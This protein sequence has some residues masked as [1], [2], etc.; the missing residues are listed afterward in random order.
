[1]KKMKF[2]QEGPMY[3]QNHFQTFA[4]MCACT[5]AINMKG[6]SVLDLMSQDTY[7]Q[8]EK[9]KKNL[10]L[11]GETKFQMLLVIGQMPTV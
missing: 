3:T 8:S 7:I 2:A 5:V 9:L 6:A 11:Q 10:I 1:M 4:S